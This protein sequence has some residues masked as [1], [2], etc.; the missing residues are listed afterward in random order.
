MRERGTYA[1][2]ALRFARPPTFS[3]L[4]EAVLAHVPVREKSL[5]GNQPPAGEARKPVRV[6]GLYTPRTR[7]PV[8]SD[9]ALCRRARVN[10]IYVQQAT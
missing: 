7:L 8:L 9:G 4:V 6:Y 2:Y 10:A 1:F 3:R 5:Y